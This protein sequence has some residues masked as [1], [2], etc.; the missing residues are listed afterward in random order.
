MSESARTVLGYEPAQ[1]LEHPSF[2]ASRIHPEDKARVFGDAAQLFAQGWRQYEYRC[3]HADGSY[4][5][6]ETG[7]SLLPAV[8]GHPAEVVGYMID[9]TVRKQAEELLREA[10]LELAR[11]AR[12]KDEF[13]ATM[14]HELRTPLNAILGFSES[15]TTAIYSPLSERQQAAVQHIETSG[16]HLLALINDI[17]DLS[18]VEAGQLSMAREWFEIAEVCQASLLFVKELAHKK[19][20]QLTFQV[21]DPLAIMEGDARRVKQILVNLLSNAVKFTPDRGEVR[22]EVTI[23]ADAGEVRFA[24]Q[25]TG[26]GIAPEEQARLFQPFVQLDSRLSRQHAGTGLGLALV[27]RLAELHG[28]RVLLESAVGVGSCFTLVLPQPP[29]APGA[30][31]RPLAT[32]SERG[33]GMLQPALVMGL[34][35]APG[36]VHAHILLAEDSA[37]TIQVTRDYLHARGFVVHIARTGWD[38]L[39]AAVAQQPD[40]ILMDIQ[41]P[42]L[43]GLALMRRLRAMPE[44]AT[45]PIIALTALSM[46]GD[47]ERCLAAGADA[48]LSKPVRLQALV[49]TIHRLLHP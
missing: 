48:Y 21:D 31:H 8:V 15:L 36:L 24:V 7:V 16:R 23:N 32:P 29:P 9:I 13:L 49:E 41:L 5:W 42:E 1:F 30:E 4:R 40:L 44:F 19:T 10:N 3:R 33:A 46:P 22:L 47:Q 28:G 43:D 39:A 6:V 35:Q 27:R 14:S 2:W 26:I 11:A 12:L 34:P 20:L 17:L 25:D 38:A 37:Q 45:T 18:K